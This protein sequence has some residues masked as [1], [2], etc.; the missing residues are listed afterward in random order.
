MAAQEMYLKK[1]VIYSDYDLIGLPQP[2]RED[3]PIDAATWEILH[4][5]DTHYD[6]ILPKTYKKNK[7]R[8]LE[9]MEANNAGPS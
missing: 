1:I 6:V 8:S 3:F 2:T 7:K 5:N 9:S 4:T